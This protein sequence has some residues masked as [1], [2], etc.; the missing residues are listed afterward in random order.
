MVFRAVLADSPKAGNY[1]L[2]LALE[3]GDARFEREVHLLSLIRQASVV[4]LEGHGTWTSPEGEAHPYIVMQWV[5]GL[6]LYA[7]AVE[8]GITVR[9][10]VGQLAQVARALEA[11]HEYGLH[12]DV[13][14]GNVRVSPEGRAVLVDFGSCWYP[15]ASPLTGRELP[16]GTAPY[17]SPQLG[18]L[19]FAL[20][21][22]STGT[23]QTQPADDVYALGITAY[24]LLAGVYPPSESDGSA[25]PEA[26]KGLNDVCPA[27]GALIKR[28]L[29]EDP[30]ARGSARQVAEELEEMLRSTRP[31]M[32]E[33]WGANASRQPTEKARPPTRREQ[34]RKE[35]M[36]HFVVAGGMC[37][38]ALFLLLMP[39]DVDRG[40]LADAEPRPNPR[41]SD[42]PDGGTSVGEEAMT[43][44][45]PAEGLPPEER[46]VSREVPSRPLDGQMRPPCTRRLTVE[47]NGACWAILLGAEKAP[48]DPTMIPKLYEHAGRCYTP[49][50]K[51]QRQPTS[52]DP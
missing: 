16:P 29:S 27:L 48:C 34:P 46:G 9:Q 14:G 41:V 43:A 8:H 1:A 38:M 37:L 30:K 32:D 17:R 23:Y 22:G 15:G 50:F 39:R 25:R 33:R 44:A 20:G 47:L 7:W 5:E 31:A 40:E 12:R 26:P 35:L 3:P 49:I 24:R 42:Q 18:L 28:M 13:K 2:K 10:A 21:L 52:K 19:E 11:T 51:G 6:S 45:A 36:P 4:R